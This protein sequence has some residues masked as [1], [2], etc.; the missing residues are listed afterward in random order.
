MN[1]MEMLL[2]GSFVFDTDLNLLLNDSGRLYLI[3]GMPGRILNIASE[4]EALPTSPFRCTKCA[5]TIPH[6]SR[7]SNLNFDFPQPR[8]LSISRHP[9]GREPFFEVRPSFWEAFSR[10]ELY[11]I[12]ILR[13]TEHI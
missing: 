10:Y 6:A 8:R 9:T 11:G 12:R 1:A 7:A 2:P 5:E 4:S 3:C 13:S